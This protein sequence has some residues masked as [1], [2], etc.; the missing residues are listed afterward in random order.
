MSENTKINNQ[1]VVSTGV[2]DRRVTH[3][4]IEFGFDIE[5]IEGTPEHE[6]VRLTFLPKA[7]GQVSLSIWKRSHGERGYDSVIPYDTVKMTKEQAITMLERV[8]QDIREMEE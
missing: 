1:I 5:L 6:N 8:I 2:P 7:D 3:S 4:Q